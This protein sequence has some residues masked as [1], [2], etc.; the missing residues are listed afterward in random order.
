MEGL[1]ASLCAG[2]KDLQACWGR[3][4]QHS[5]NKWGHPFHTVFQAAGDIEYFRRHDHGEDPLGRKRTPFMNV[6]HLTAL[7]RL[8]PLEI[9]SHEDWPAKALGTGQLQH[10]RS[11][12]LENGMPG[13]KLPSQLTSL[14][15]L[16][17]QDQEDGGSRG[18][19]RQV[20]VLPLCLHEA[21]KSCTGSLKHV[22]LHLPVPGNIEPSRLE[23]VPCTQHVTSLHLQSWDDLQ[24]IE[25]VMPSST[26]CAGYFS[27]LRIISI[28]L[29]HTNHTCLEPQWDF[30]SCTSLVDFSLELCLY[31]QRMVEGIV[32]LT[33]EQFQLHALDK[34]SVAGKCVLNCSSWMLQHANVTYNMEDCPG[35]I[36]SQ[37]S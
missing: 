35:P 13:C 19:G 10:L 28:P 1:K 5:G 33:S 15:L 30:S 36:V 22:A 37:V 11:L 24:T 12:H 20:I 14:Q 7:Q 3:C 34:G 31:V 27:Q 18:W 29:R 21:V 9:L 16:A 8:W 17:H 26:W 23:R 4:P 32:N 6:N 25:A 2:A